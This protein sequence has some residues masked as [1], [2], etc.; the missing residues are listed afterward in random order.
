MYLEVF[1]IFFLRGF[2]SFVG[3]SCED[4]GLEDIG[5]VRDV[6]LLISGEN[7]CGNC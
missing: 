4:I 7:G 2:S 3:V 1:D 5:L 6:G